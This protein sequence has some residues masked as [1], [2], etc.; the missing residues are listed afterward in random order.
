MKDDGGTMSLPREFQFSQ[1]SL[2]DFE[3]CPRRFK[4][5]Y[6]DK[7]RWPAIESEPVQE[8]ELLARLGADFHRLVHQHL[9][10]VDVD[11]LTAT[12]ESA[13]ADLQNWWHNY[14]THR[15]ADL[16]DAQIYPELPLS[17]PLRNYRLFARFDTLAVG[18][19][20]SFLIIDWKTSRRK[21][22]R[23]AL[24][25]R[26]QTR[27]YP[28]VLAA[29]GTAFNRGRSIDPATIK[30]V[31][32]YPQFPDEPEVFEHST[33]LRQRDEQFLSELIERIKHSA[34]QN[35]FPL[36]EDS[37]PCKYCVYRSLCDRGHQA[38]SLE[39]LDED[40]EEALDVSALDWDPIAEIQF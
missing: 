25:R 4:L 18:A 22:P 24:E 10:G 17:T 14:L 21:P 32:W 36:V 13:D 30:M 39:T 19:D 26:M 20:G 34:G 29:A 16:S 31:Y 37:K 5:R 28:F 15:P 27:V 12:L 3:T 33:K 9:V 1:S 38:G 2:Q 40:L 8:A 11:T 23:A 6:L 35:D 7:L